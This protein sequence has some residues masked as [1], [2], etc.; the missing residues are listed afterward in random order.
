MNT[1]TEQNN[2]DAL[3]AL[4]KALG[5]AMEVKNEREIVV[6][7][8]KFKAA[9]A[10]ELVHKL[11][12]KPARTKASVRLFDPESFIDYVN[13]H[14]V[15]GASRIFLSDD[16]PEDVTFTAIIDMH[17]A[18]ETAWCQHLAVLKLEQTEEWSRF[19]KGVN[20]PLTQNE[21]AE[22]LEENQ[23]GITDPSGASLLELVQNLSGRNN[24]SYDSATRLSNGKMKIAYSEDVQLTRKGETEEF[25]EKIVA[26]IA[27]F[28]GA[29]LYKFPCR[30]R[31]RIQD[32]KLIFT[33]RPVDIHLV[34]RDTIS[35][36]RDRI[37]SKCGI[38]IFRGSLASNQ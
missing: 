6:I 27:P 25:P 1:A 35:N 19:M 9:S 30:I 31:Y 13:E 28:E 26:V 32:R 2:V 34:Y 23:D 18:V 29:P 12:P 5:D 38:P 21:F 11:L 17:T 24:I 8:E 33:I 14:K 7:P 3:V 10:F 37:A 4:G 20:K 36:I 16:A 15:G 22:F